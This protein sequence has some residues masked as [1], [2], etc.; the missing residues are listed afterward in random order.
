MSAEGADH[1]VRDLLFGVRIATI[2]RLCFITKQVENIFDGKSWVF[3]QSC[4]HILHAEILE[5]A[6]FGL[7]VLTWSEQAFQNFFPLIEKVK[8]V[9]EVVI[10]QGEHAVERS[11]EVT[12]ADLHQRALIETVLVFCEVIIL[13]CQRGQRPYVPA[14]LP[15]HESTELLIHRLLLLEQ[16]FELNLV[17][18]HGEAIA[19]DG[20]S[21]HTHTLILVIA[22]E[23]QQDRLAFLAAR[24]EHAGYE[25]PVDVT[26]LYQAD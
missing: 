17:W 22:Q 6:S 21:R 7:G 16:H 4:L 20:C 10:I 19:E 25:L 13:E 8:L 12:R 23:L 18:I 26:L 11:Q 15:W 5:Q 14:Y 24:A 3:S 1:L 9:D 2:N